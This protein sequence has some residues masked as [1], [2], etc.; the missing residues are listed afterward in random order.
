MSINGDP[1]TLETGEVEPYRISPAKLKRM[2]KRSHVLPRRTG[3]MVKDAGVE[4]RRYNTKQAAAFFGKTNQW[5]YW[6]LKPKAKKGGDLFLLDDGT[7]IEP[8]WSGNARFYTL[9]VIKEMAVC[10]YN[11]DK[12]SEA[13]FRLVLEKILVAE[14]GGDWRRVG[15]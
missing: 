2:T 13:K 3:D 6:A 12:L 5:M 7:R 14:A 15:Y 4:T 8:D 9:D 1:A 11:K 10:L